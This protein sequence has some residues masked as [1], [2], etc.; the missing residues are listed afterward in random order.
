MIEGN[1]VLKVLIS[2]VDLDEGLESSAQAPIFLCFLG[3][4]LA[5]FVG[6][7]VVV[8]SELLL[9]SLDDLFLKLRV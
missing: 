9:D 2:L 3:D 8:L 1:S 4:P 6:L 7:S 5:R